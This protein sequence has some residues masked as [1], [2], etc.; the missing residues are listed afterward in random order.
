I[1]RQIV[2]PDAD[3]LADR[4]L[5]DLSCVRDEDDRCSKRHDPADPRCKRWTKLHM[6][7]TRYVATRV[8]VH[9]AH[10]DHRFAA[11]MARLHVLR[12][13]RCELG[14]MAKHPR[15]SLVQRAHVVKIRWITGHAGPEPISE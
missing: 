1:A 9:R 13:E 12:A 11:S 7:D 4:V 10:V 2:V 5:M 14:P 8:L 15:P 6:V 3:E